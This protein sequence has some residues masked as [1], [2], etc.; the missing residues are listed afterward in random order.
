MEINGEAAAETG[1]EFPAIPPMRDAIV[2]TPA[3]D[4]ATTAPTVA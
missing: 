3:N 4:A 1:P 2:P